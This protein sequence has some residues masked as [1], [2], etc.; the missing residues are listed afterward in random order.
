MFIAQELNANKINWN[1]ENIVCFQ[2]LLH[3][4]QRHLCLNRRIHE[5]YAIWTFEQIERRQ[6]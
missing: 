3:S 1:C 5:A 6:A 2:S 4:K